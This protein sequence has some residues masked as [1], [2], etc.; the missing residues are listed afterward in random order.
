VPPELKGILSKSSNASAEPKFS[1]FTVAPPLY[2]II[3]ILAGA[4]TRA[5]KSLAALLRSSHG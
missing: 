4:D 5:E 2:V 1:P 3:E